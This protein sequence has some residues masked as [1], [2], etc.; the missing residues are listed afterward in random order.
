M[1]TGI[2]SQGD[3]LVKLVNSEQLSLAEKSFSSPPKRVVYSIQRQKCKVPIFLRN[4]N[5]AGFFVISMLIISIPWEPSIKSSRTP[6]SCRQNQEI[7]QEIIPKAVAKS[8][9]PTIPKLST[10][11]RDE[12]IK[13]SDFKNF[14]TKA[15]KPVQQVSAQKRKR[16]VIESEDEEENVENE[17]RKYAGSVNSKANSQRDDQSTKKK[18]NPS[19]KGKSVLCRGDTGHRH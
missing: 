19:N 18:Q 13:T 6:F 3:I 12:K 14:F 16:V 10:T 9:V 17:N 5:D 4:T 7:T 8:G 11:G 1:L 15:E 2:S